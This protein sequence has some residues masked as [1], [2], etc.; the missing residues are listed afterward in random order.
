VWQ[1]FGLKHIPFDVVTIVLGNYDWAEE[2]LKGDS[3]LTSVDF[4]SPIRSFGLI[5]YIYQPSKIAMTVDD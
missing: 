3:V 5:N 2:D 4:D 1:P